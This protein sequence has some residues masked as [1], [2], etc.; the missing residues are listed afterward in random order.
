VKN[1]TLVAEDVGAL[2][3]AKPEGLALHWKPERAAQLSEG[4]AASTY[5][6]VRPKVVSKVLPVMETCTDA[7][8]GLTLTLAK[9]GAE[10]ANVNDER[11]PSTST[12]ME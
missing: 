2:N 10:T 4:A 1:L 8:E 6:Q 9:V 11:T 3:V 7:D 5:V 12:R